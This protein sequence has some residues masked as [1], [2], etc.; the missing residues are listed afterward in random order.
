MRPIPMKLR[1]EM[2]EDSYYESCARAN[3]GGCKGRITWEHAFMY[4][5]KQINERWAIIPLCVYHHLGPGLDKRKNERI[6]IARAT[7]QDL[8][9]YPRKNWQTYKQ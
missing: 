8:Q 7:E 6:A 1:L 3:E 9:K 2:A 4:A 5:G